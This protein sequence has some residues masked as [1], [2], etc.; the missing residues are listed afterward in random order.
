[1]AAFGGGRIYT[2]AL[3]VFVSTSRNHN[4]RKEIDVCSRKSQKI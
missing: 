4:F 1:M 3:L 2:C